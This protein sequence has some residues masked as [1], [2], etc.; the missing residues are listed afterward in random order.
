MA[1]PGAGQWLEDMNYRQTEGMISRMAAGHSGAADALAGGI[2]AR[3]GAVARPLMSSAMGMLGLDPMSIGLKA[4]MG[5]WNAGAGVMG[6]GL[7]GA[8]AM[9]GV[10]IL[11]AGAAFVGNQLY[12]GAQQQ[13]QLNQ[14]MRSS[15]NFINSQGGM[16]FTSQQGYQIG[17]HLRGMAGDFGPAGE[18][19]TFG[20]LSRLATNMGRMG[21]G[22]DVRSVKEF[23]DKFKEMVTT[24]KTIATDMGS[25]LEEAQKFMQSMRGSGIFR[26]AD[27]LRMSSATRIGAAAG[28]LAMSEMTGMANIGSQISRSVGGLGRQGAFGGMKTM[29]QIGLAQRVGAINDEDV[30]NAT[31]L[32]GAEGRQALATA[33]MQQSARF[34]S[35]G[36][37]RRFLAS[38]SG[39]DGS[40][41]EDAVQEYLM[42][43]NMTTGRTMELAHQNLEGVGRAN[44]IRNEGRLRGAALEKF[45]GLA[46][47]MVYKQWLSSRGYDPT[48]MDDKSMLAFQRFSGMGRDEADLAIKQIQRMP[49]MMHEM[50]QAKGELAYS[51]ELNKYNKTIG[52]EGLKRRFD[53]AR[54]HIQGKMQ[55]AGADIMEQGSDVLAQW[56]N[57]TMGVYERRT[58]EGV[59][60][61][62]RMA[63]DGH[64]DS[65]RQMDR[66]LGG[67]KIMPGA[68]RLGMGPGATLGGGGL[69]NAM[70]LSN[71]NNAVD[72]ASVTGT[73][74]DFM[75]GNASAFRTAYVDQAAG[76][77]GMARADAIMEIVKHQ[78]GPDAQK[79]LTEYNAT[80]DPNKKLAIAA[81]MEKAAG[82]GDGSS[83]GKTLTAQNL[84][85]ND[86][87]QSSAWKRALGIGTNAGATQ[88]EVDKM[89]GEGMIGAESKAA[90]ELRKGSKSALMTGLA[91]VTGGVSLLWDTGER[92]AGYFGEKADNEAAG[93][94][95]RTSEGRGLIGGIM[96]GKGSD[97][98]AAMGRLAELKTKAQSGELARGD[99]AQLDVLQTA[100]AARVLGMHLDKTGK[101]IDQLS[102]AEKQAL[103]KEAGGIIGRPVSFDELV[104]GAQGV[105]GALRMNRDA[106]VRQAREQTEV[107][108]KAL[109]TDISSGGIASFDE[110]GKLTV[111]A[112]KMDELRKAGGQAAVDAYNMALDIA[113]TK[114]DGNTEHDASTL[115]S[116]YGGGGKNGKYAQLQ[117]KIAGASLAEKRAIARQLGGADPVAQMYATSAARQERLENQIKH[118]KAGAGQ[119]ETAMASLMGINVDK[120]L[121]GQM[122]GGDVDT[123]AAL[124]MQQQGIKASDSGAGGY[125]AQLVKALQE[126]RSGKMG[127]AADALSAAEANASDDVK[128][129]LEKFRDSKMSA[130]DQSAKHL[131]KMADNSDEMKKLMGQQLEALQK[132]AKLDNPDSGN[133]TK[134][135]S[136]QPGGGKTG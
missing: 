38:I 79:L 31:G 20:E 30:Y 70:R 129:K 56:F 64:V 128:K 52:V 58:I 107:E 63:K 87:G 45:G 49:E 110:S 66:L 123:V 106:A 10:G 12:S 68:D 96:E 48:S 119:M 81:R 4:G 25:S 99:K 116:L 57:R 127:S 71:A 76:K 24:L 26:T 111:K 34:L 100:R 97:Y 50:R 109:R 83:I 69:S 17:S 1:Y 82:L 33:Q 104:K 95:T 105:A 3:G 7:M 91:G 5:A 125:K 29:E 131:S 133:G 35:T 102:D 73:D 23:K 43:G 132:L 40:L 18:V 39:R 84:N 120:E 36:R 124:L 122:A 53:Q 21:M 101:S 41:N 88:A 55:Q 42:G 46:Q 74:L 136:T 67:S 80:T 126:G 86:S 59:D 78:G 61:V 113:G 27:Q 11:G 114:F 108:T 72:A 28:G 89:V 118:T 130:A 98:D 8:G 16:G 65:G 2:L 47:S 15:Y 9:A 32:S 93:A 19:A 77:G 117:Q 54:E 14:G 51:D 37:G 22:G 94:W 13:Y 44:F 112:G 103:A 115:N 75:R 90:R 60:K 6:A 62:L 134:G 121:R 92:I 135:G 85:I